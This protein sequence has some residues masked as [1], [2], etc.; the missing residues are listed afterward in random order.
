MTEPPKIID[1]DRHVAA[2]LERFRLR[3]WGMR[4]PICL[5]F[6]RWPSL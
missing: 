4:S 5:S 2:A 1:W 6:W 3:S